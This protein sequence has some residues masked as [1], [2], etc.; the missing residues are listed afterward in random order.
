MLG[1]INLQTSNLMSIKNSLDYLNIPFSIITEPAQ[2]L[3][4]E[5]IILPG[6]GTFGN[7]IRTLKKLDLFNALK[8]H[9]Q[10]HNKP[11]LGIC[12][13]MQMLFDKSEESPEA[14]GLSLLSGEVIKLPNSQNYTIPRIGWAKSM[15][16][17]PFLNF[18]LN[19]DFD[20]YYIHSFYVK[21]ENQTDIAIVTETDITAAVHNNYIYGCQFHPEKSH[22]HGLEILK[23]FSEIKTEMKI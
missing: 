12:L 8:E 18:E 17:A 4:V 5:K 9:V 22:I 1:I 15:T 11:I 13:G 3:N 14:E 20:F 6:V 7:G 10:L 19:Q 23:R 21:P 2:L 16:V